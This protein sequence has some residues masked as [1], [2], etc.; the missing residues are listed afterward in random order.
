MLHLPTDCK[1][2]N[3]NRMKRK[4]S[5]LALTI[6]I[7]FNSCS[8]SDNDKNTSEI[9]INPPS[10][11]QGKWLL[12]DSTVGES[13]W[14]FTNNDFIII[15]VNTELSQ[16]NQ[17]QQFSNNGQEVSASDTSSENSYSVVLN[18]IGGQSTTYSFSKIS[19]NEITWDTV[20]NS[21]YTK[22]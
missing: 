18:S 16:R 5:F 1:F 6:I 20:A 7:I 3:Y 10:W 9:Q 19:D 14:R 21:I 22:Q 8:N 12:P 2:K 4:V 15:Q 17:L 13:G 11:I